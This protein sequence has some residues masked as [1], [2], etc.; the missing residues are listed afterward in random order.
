MDNPLGDSV[1][2]TEFE[3]DNSQIKTDP[4]G[5]LSLWEKIRVV[6]RDSTNER[7]YNTWLEAASLEDVVDTALGKLLKSAF[8]VPFIRTGYRPILC[9]T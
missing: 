9:L 1:K 2:M 4:E 8:P 6:L 5:S 7:L 3:G